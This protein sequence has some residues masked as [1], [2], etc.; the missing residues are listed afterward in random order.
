MKQV[1]FGH[2][3]IFSVRAVPRVD[4]AYASRIFAALILADETLVTYSARYISI[5]YYPITRFEAIDPFAQHFDR[6]RPFMPGSNRERYHSILY[7]RE[8]A[9]IDTVVRAA[10]AAS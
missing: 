10:D 1:P 4:S 9:C 2:Q 7:K 3:D 5:A 6:S 8:L